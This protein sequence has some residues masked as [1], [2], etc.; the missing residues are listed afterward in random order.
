MKIEE[1]TAME[2]AESKGF[3]VHKNLKWDDNKNKYVL[4]FITICHGD[5]VIHTTQKYMTDAEILE[6]ILKFKK[7]NHYYRVVE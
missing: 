4:C 3:T 5:G 6:K 7:K 1:I 2:W